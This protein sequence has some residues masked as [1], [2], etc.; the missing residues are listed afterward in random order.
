MQRATCKSESSDMSMTNT[1]LHRGSTWLFSHSSADLCREPSWKDAPRKRAKGLQDSS[2]GMCTVARLA[3][4]RS[5]L[6]LNLH[7]EAQRMWLLS[8]HHDRADCRSKAHSGES[9]P[10]E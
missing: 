8:Q 9:W 1:R 4:I 10:K 6:L 2:P 5:F 7:H 3:A